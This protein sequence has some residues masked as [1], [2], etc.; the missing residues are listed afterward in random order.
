MFERVLKIVEEV[1][2]ILKFSYPAVEQ[3]VIPPNTNVVQG[4]FTL[5][6]KLGITLVISGKTL[7]SLPSHI[8]K[9]V[10]SPLGL[11]ACLQGM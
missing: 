7:K 6:S 4:L 11:K 8:I 3:P 5:I 1:F 10:N 9:H 2:C